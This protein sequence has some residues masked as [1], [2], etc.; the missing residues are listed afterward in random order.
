M[1]YFLGADLGSTKTHMALADEHGRLL[2]F[3]RSGAGN[4]QSV[5]FDGMLQSIQDGLAQV[6]AQ[7]QLAASDIAGAGFGIAGYDWPSEEGQMAGIIAHLG[8]TCPF[9]MVN[10]AIPALFAVTESGRG[11]ALVSGTGCNCRGWDPDT[12]REGRVTGYGYHMGEFAGSAELVWRA[13][14]LVSYEWTQ[15]SLHTALSTRLIDYCGA[16]DLSDLIEGYT[17][18]YYTIGAKVAPLI[19]AVAEQGDAVM[20]ELIRWAGI[21]LGEMACAVIRQ[22]DFAAQG[23]DVVLAG[24]MF[25]GGPLLIGPM[26]QTIQEFAPQARLVNLD[27]PPVIGAVVLGMVQGGFK[28]SPEVRRTLTDALKLAVD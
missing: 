7:S 5:G 24:S 16:K 26:W 28:A 12:R 1:R 2:A 9:G 8:L 22:L 3:A 4:Y 20:R 18:G 27:V 25:S 13:M 6:L 21:E 23:F 11:V 19:F 14:Q 10:D 17:K 15:R